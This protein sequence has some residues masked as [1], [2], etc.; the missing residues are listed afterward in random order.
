MKKLILILLLLLLIGAGAVAWMLLGSATGFTTSKQSV[1][2]PSKAATRTAVLDSLSRNKIVTNTGAF[3][4]LAGRMKYWTGIKP[5]KYEIQKGSSLIDIVRILRHGV[6]TPVNLTITKIRTPE[7]FARI[8]GRR[9]ECDSAQVMDLLG[10]ADSLKIFGTTPGQAM[11]YILP[12][13][14]TFFWTTPPKKIYARLKEETEKFWT[15]ERKTKAAQLGLNPVTAYIL[16]SI[17]EEETLDMDEKDTIASVYL[18]RIRVG[19]PLQADPTVKFALKDFSLTRIYGAHLD[20]PSPYNTYRNRGLPPGPICT[21][22]KKTIDAVLAAP[23]TEYVY[24]VA[25]PHF[26]GTHDFSTNYAE[27]RVKARRYQQA[28]REW[29]TQRAAKATAK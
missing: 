18:N 7:D 8:A 5:G 11:A 24:F 15:E 17:V 20:A 16:A 10:N 4:W 27:H 12:D 21:P 13:T 14:Y 19:M 1:Y 22:S 23:T 2:I 25:S 26:D 3:D 29:A 6:Q 28:Y 9:F